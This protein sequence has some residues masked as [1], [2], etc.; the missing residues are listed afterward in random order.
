VKRNLFAVALALLLA[1]GVLSGCDEETGITG[2]GTVSN[3]ILLTVGVSRGAQ[4]GGAVGSDSSY[5][6]FVSTSTDQTITLSG[7]SSSAD[8]IWGIFSSPGFSTPFG[9]CDTG[10][11]SDSCATGTITSGATYY[12]EVYNKT[13]TDTTYTILITNT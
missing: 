7:I 8:L 12:I 2:E 13:F 1:A 4:V 11:T 9:T 5:Y 3:P 10:V 6:Y